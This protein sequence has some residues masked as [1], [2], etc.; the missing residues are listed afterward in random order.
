MATSQIRIALRDPLSAGAATRA[1]DLP[2][3][4]DSGGVLRAPSGPIGLARDALREGSRV[5]EVEREIR[6]GV[7]EQPRALADDH[8]ADE[9]A[10][11]VEELVLE[12]PPDQS[13]AAVHLQLAPRPGLEL[14][15]GRREVAGEDGRAGPLRVGEVFH[16]TYFGFV[17]K[18]PTMGSSRSSLTPQ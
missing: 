6:A 3:P 8:R 4:R 17:F 7:G 2:S 11:L 10:E 1:V 12:Q 16:A 13:A 15:D 9:Q 5:D 14:T 18:A